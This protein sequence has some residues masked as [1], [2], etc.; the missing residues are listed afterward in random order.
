MTKFHLI[1]LAKDFLHMTPKAEATKEKTVKMDLLQNRKFW[2][3]KDKIHRVKMQLVPWRE[4]F[5][6]RDSGKGLL[7]IVYRV[8]IKLNNYTKKPQFHK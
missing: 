6:N 7:S 3:A 4:I 8:L 5:A 1:G 2:A